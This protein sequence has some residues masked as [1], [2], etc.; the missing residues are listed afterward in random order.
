MTN[1]K[2]LTNDLLLSAFQSKYL[3]FTGKGG[4][5]NTTLAS[6][7]AYALAAT[8]KVLLI[9]TD[10]ASNLQDVFETS[11]GSEPVEIKDRPNLSVVNLDPIKAAREY[12]EKVAS[13]YRGILPESMIAQMEE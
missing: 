3:F 13:P 5:G 10:P 11:L 12:K 9:S 6:S 1:I 7:I 4:D 2:R 8:R